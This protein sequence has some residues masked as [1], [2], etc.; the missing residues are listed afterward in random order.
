MKTL[1]TGGA[2]FIGRHLV[3]ALTRNGHDIVVLDSLVEQVHG[4]GPLTPPFP[5]GTEFIRDDTRSLEA[6]ARALTSA[7]NVVHLA[8]QTGVGQSMYEIARYVD[9]ND[10]GTAVLLQAVAERP[11]P[12]RRLVLS[13]SRAIYGEGL[14]LCRHCGEVTPRA[15]DRSGL[16]SWE[17]RCPSC[18]GEVTVTATHE[19][20]A[21]D[22]ASVYAATKL[23]QERLCSL[24]GGAYGFSTVALR[25]FNVYGPGQSLN[26]PY[27]GLL[28]TFYSRLS[29]NRPLNVYEDG[30]MLRDFIAVRDVVDALEKA[31]EIDESLLEH[32]VFN[33][34]T[35]APNTVLDLAATLRDLMGSTS[36][37]TVTGAYRLGDIRHSIAD[38]TRARNE[39]G[40]AAAT[41]LQEGLNLWLAWAADQQ[42]EDTTDQAQ[43]ILQSRGLYRAARD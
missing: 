8:S 26:N 38:T 40:F 24:I 1:I 20:A 34:A 28:S 35:G 22:P 15:V 13:S 25:L 11:A 3:E 23:Q 32:R 33:V 17:L 16:P 42:S 4:P 30:K 18:A 36:E 41:S 19:D 21:A 39:L 2:G 43:S 9:A 12:L 10:H 6:V 31:I 5:R 37:I 7:D 14:Y 27:T 29:S